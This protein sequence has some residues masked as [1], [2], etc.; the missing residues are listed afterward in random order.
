MDRDNLV[1]KIKN[2]LYFPNLE[3]SSLNLIKKLIKEKEIEA[4]LFEEIYNCFKEFESKK[5]ECFFIT[6]SFLRTSLLD[7]NFEYLIEFHEKEIFIKEP[8]F[9]KK[10]PFQWI[11][12]E[13][14]EFENKMN[15][16]IKK[17][18]SRVSINDTKRF[19]QENIEVFL[20]FSEESILNCLNNPDLIKLINIFTKESGIEILIGEYFEKLKFVKL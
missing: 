1:N 2:D 6:F 4:Q 14:N 19:I 10:I 12:D 13:I 16:E 9:S 17:Y 3:K 5:R 11:S 18:S 7:N 8:L 20:K 15:L